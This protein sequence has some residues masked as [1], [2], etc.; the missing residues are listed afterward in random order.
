MLRFIGQ[1][2]SAESVE[3]GKTS[4]A[5]ARPVA[6]AAFAQ[7]F[8]E[9][10][11][12]PG[13][14]R[15]DRLSAA[16]AD[17]KILSGHNFLLM[18]K[19][20][21]GK[22]GSM[23]CG[24]KLQKPQKNA[25]ERDWPRRGINSRPAGKIAPPR[26]R[27]RRSGH[28]AGARQKSGLFRENEGGRR[29]KKEAEGSKRGGFPV[30]SRK[31]A[32]RKIRLGRRRRGRTRGRTQRKRE[33][34]KTDGIKAGSAAGRKRAICRRQQERKP[35]KESGSR[36]KAPKSGKK[37]AEREGKRSFGTPKTENKEENAPKRCTFFCFCSIITK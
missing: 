4:A 2:L 17:R 31:M 27:T 29:R 35:G 5:Y 9:R 14:P 16:A 18:Q 10:R 6:G 25:S 36:P 3:R 11:T 23:P 7:T 32:R 37:W 22:G 28:S 20:C 12:A 19:V 13:R 30:H 33:K 1:V 8:S 15:V 34:H 21:P 26:E 24:G